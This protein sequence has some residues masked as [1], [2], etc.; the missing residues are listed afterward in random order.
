M[1]RRDIRLPDGARGWWLASQVEH[2]RISAQ[3]A[4]H[5]N[6]PLAAAVRREVLAAILHHDDGWAEWES[7]PRIDAEHGRPIE[8]LEL[9][10]A[11]AREVWT[12]SIASAAEHG[13]LAGRMVAGHF[14]RLLAFSESSRRD[15]AATAWRADM[16][17]RRADWLSQWQAA[18]PALHTC[19]LA[20]AA[21]EWLWTF[22]RASLWLC[23]DAPAPGETGAGQS[24]F[25]P[26]GAGTPLE[27][28]FSGAGA[29]VVANAAHVGGA[30]R[31]AAVAVPWRFDRDWI[32][33]DAAGLLVPAARYNDAR[34]LLAA[35][36]PHALRWR[37]TAP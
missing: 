30:D 25:N 5:C 22:D 33:V 19:E 3:L 26:A 7:S 32:D 14:L 36:R 23:C 20:D 35:G 1:I 27:M 13:P 21:I 34:T 4:R 17:R 12:R 31:A 11:D 8:F 10:A 18:D 24:D 2:A 6:A 16:N 28:H 37:L 15:A 29:A 9:D